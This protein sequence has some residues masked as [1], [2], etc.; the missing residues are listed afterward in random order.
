MLSR[1]PALHYV[2]S[3]ME[4]AEE[5]GLGLKSM[6]RLAG[7]SDL[8][9]PAYRWEDPYLVLQVLRSHQGAVRMLPEQKR[10]E[11]S[12]GELAGWQWLRG[13]GRAKS[14]DY[15]QSREIAERVA[16]RHLNHFVELGLA[17]KSGAGPSTSYEVIA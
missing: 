15:A 6:K 12:A 2:F 3:R 13:R 17:R 7:E 4:L 10:K 9:L 11:L 8:P 5:R 14:S 1:N 16:R